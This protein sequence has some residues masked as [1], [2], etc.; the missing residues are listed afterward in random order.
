MPSPTATDRPPQRG[1]GIGRLETEADLLR[2]IQQSQK[3]GM[4]D[5]T[6]VSGLATKLQALST[7]DPELAAIAALTSAVDTLPYFT[8]SGTAALAAFTAAGRA[9][10]DD[11]DAAAQRTTL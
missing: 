5:I 9:L 4:F 2:F 10:V 7:L 3:P 8:G 6:T 1:N 11:A